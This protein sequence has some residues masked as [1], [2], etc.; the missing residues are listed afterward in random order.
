MGKKITFL[1]VIVATF[2]L[3]LPTQAAISNQPVSKSVKKAYAAGQLKGINAKVKN[4][5]VLNAPKTE[6]MTQA[7]Q[8]LRQSTFDKA[9][10]DRASM[11]KF[12]ERNLE[13]TKNGVKY[14]K[15]RHLD[16]KEMALAGLNEKF[17]PQNAGRFKASARAPKRAAEDLVT[18]PSTATVET[19]YTTS[20]KFY[21]YGSSGWQ[22]ATSYMKN[23]N[24]VIDGSDIYLQGLA[25]FFGEA[26]VKGTIA[27][28]TATFANNQLLGEDDYGPEYLS[29]SDDGSTLSSSIVFNY[30]ATEGTLR[31][32]TTFIFENSTDDDVDPYT[33]WSEPT[34]SKAEPAA[35]EVVVA[36]EGL[37]TEDYVIKAHNYKNDADVSVPLSIGFDG[38]DVYVQGL[39]SYIPEA[40]AK[41]TLSGT[42]VTFAYGQFFGTYAS[43]Y[44][45][46]LNTLVGEDVVFTY[47]AT[48]GT[49]TAQNEFFLVDNDQYY[50]DSYRGAVINKVVEIAATPA[51][52][53]ITA[54]KNGNYGWYITFNIPLQDT[55][56]NALVASKLSYEI[57]TDVMEDVNPL[58]FTP[59]T[60]S[61]LTENLTVIPYGFTEN[62]DFYADQIYLNEL[63]SATWNK[64]GIKSIYTGGGETHETAI[65]WYTIKPYGEPEAETADPVEAPYANA[66]NTADLFAE[67]GVIDANNDGKTWTFGSKSLPQYSYSSDNDA[68]DWFVSPAVKL[69]AGKK[70]HFAIDAYAALAS[71]PERL[72]VKMGTAPKASALTLSVIPSTDITWATAETLEN[73]NVSVE[74]TGYY[75]FGI[76]AISDAD[77]FNLYVANFLIEAGA[78]ATAPDS[79]TELS[80]VATENKLEATVSFNAPTKAVNGTDLTSNLTKIEILRDGEVIKTLE[81]VAPGAAQSYV[82]NDNLTMGNH[83]YQVIPYNEAGKGVKSEEKTVFLSAEITVPTTFDLSKKDVFEF[84]QVIDANEDD[85]TWSWG[86]SYGTSC[87]YNSSLSA[88]D[89]LVSPAIKLEAGK[90]YNIII[91]ARN[92]GY[93]ERFEVKA[94]KVASVEGLNITAIQ[95]TIVENG[96]LDDF[97]GEFSVAEGGLYFLA[98]HSIS[99]PDMFRLIVDKFTIEQGASADAPAVVE[100]FVAAPGAEGAIEANISFKAPSKAINGNALTEALTKVEILRD[101][102]VVK[103]LENVA[104]GSA[105]NWKDENVEQGKTYVYQVIP[106]NEAGRGTKSEKQSVFIGVDVPA[107]ITGIS[108][109]DQQ[110]KVTFNWD[111]VTVGQNGGYVNPAQVEY[112]IWSTAWVEGW[113]GEE[114]ALDEK[115]DSVFATTYTLN[116]ANTDEGTQDYTYWGLQPRNA[117]GEGDASVASL[118]TGAPYELPFTETF[119][120][121]SF[122]SLW[123]YD[124]VSLYIYN[125]SSDGDEVALNL[126]P[127][128]EVGEGYLLSGKINLNNAINPTLL[129]DGFSDAAGKLS[130]IGF[131]P[132]N[133][134]QVLLAEVPFTNQFS[135]VKVPL[136]SIKD[137]RYNRVA[138][139]ANFVNATDSFI[140]DN[141]RIVDL[142]EHDLA[143]N[144]KAAK[145]LIAGDSTIVKVTVENKAENAA[146]GY[147]VKLTAGD[148]ELLNVTP[149]AI[150]AFSS[151]EFTTTFKTSIFD[152]AADIVLKAQVIYTNDL[153]PDNNTDETILSVKEPTATAPENFLAKQTDDTIE[154]SWTTS[155]TSASEN[156]ESFEDQTTFVP[157]GLGGITATEH[158]GAFGD[159]T[160]YDGNGITVYGFNSLSYEN[161]GEPQAWAVFNPALAGSDFEASYEAYNGEQFLWSFCPVDESGAPKADHW[162]ISPELTG[163]AQTIKF[164]YRVITEQ[165]GAETF[166]VLYS[167]TDKNPQS[168]TKVKDASV[169]ETSWTEYSFDI[170]EGAKYFA[171]RHTSEDIFGLLIDD[172]TFTSVGKAP[173]SFNIYVDAV[174]Q[175]STTEKSFSIEV[176]ELVGSH[177][178]GVSA[179][180]ENG[181]ESKVVTATVD[182]VN[183]IQSIIASGKPFSIYTLDGK[184]ISKQATSLKGLKGAYVIDNKKVVLK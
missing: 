135:T 9:A 106:Y 59:A 8:Q 33:Y 156:T 134:P 97:E 71:Y 79:V 49:F 98:I 68:D 44:D 69:E 129:F 159:W 170:P 22:D 150:P 65:Q 178:F 122:H 73:S 82:D 67:F 176:D 119:A 145:G 92:L 104:L 124:N 163:V 162:L 19:W 144:V 102:A 109:L 93:P 148:K 142:Y 177:V 179:V 133:Q 58:T 160:V 83:T 20:G 164:F 130:I 56:G 84:F 137:A 139:F 36:P 110:T 140:I 62:Y 3:S 182:V 27:G 40:W 107:D 89:Y 48:A 25:Y 181:A 112:I 55:E 116:W 167:T 30:D 16:R 114:L 1:L 32:V 81:N 166:E 91:K 147:T 127:G 126:Q 153:N 115:L 86:T 183:A 46:Y 78:E 136:A 29:G 13:N 87:T 14:E 80:V 175:A 143:V 60:H 169:A 64:I 132:D 12:F 180:Y 28:S 72:E 26:W 54:L 138:F 2:L 53:A 108:V 39:C 7:L 171:I 100:N 75:H 173:V 43:T 101:D 85:K 61:K 77:N 15:Y 168:F 105:Q 165:Y 11:E 50:F 128:D 157:F 125:G 37:V 35:P 131:K 4:A 10:L 17:A 149:E 94:G 113:L 74:E 63:Y 45:M 47:D 120:G 6:D 121:K 18:P 96:E 5:F 70:Y 99:D 118:L 117:A 174:K 152:E 184:L 34:F 158:T 172:I 154:L 42:T 57:F 146:Q 52:P 155:D 111:A 103:T 38:N 161:M 31:A 24:V 23:I 76:H 151:K 95:P 88:D 141:I 41:G 66:L 123:D 21:V 90:N 51:N